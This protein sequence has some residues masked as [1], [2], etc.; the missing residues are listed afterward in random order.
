M[1]QDGRD[2]LHVRGDVTPGRDGHVV[3]EFQAALV[4]QGR[5]RRS[6]VLEAVAK[7]EMVIG[8]AEGVQF[9]VGDR[10]A[11][12]DAGDGGPF[13]RVWV[14]VADPDVAEEMGSSP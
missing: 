2:H 10:A 5:D 7:P 14:A 12:A 6:D 9:A 1:F 3:E 8:Y 4:A 11:A 13:D